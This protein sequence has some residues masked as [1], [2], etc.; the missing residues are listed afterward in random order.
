MNT[1]IE[2]IR[3]INAD[4]ELRKVFPVHA[5]RTD[6]L[7]QCC[8]VEEIRSA[9][10]SGEVKFGRTINDFYFYENTND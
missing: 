8:T 3:K 1:V 9:V 2:A 4:K 6:L 7:A 10:L 5:M